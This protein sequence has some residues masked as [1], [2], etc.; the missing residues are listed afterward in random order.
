MCGSSRKRLRLAAGPPS[1]APPPAL[2]RASSRRAAT[3]RASDPRP[4]PPSQALPHGRLATPHAPRPCPRRLQLYAASSLAFNAAPLAG[5]ASPRASVAMA[6]VD[7]M[8][9]KY[10]V[11]GTVYDP[12][13]LST[14]FDLNWMREAELKHGRLCMLAVSGWLAVDYGIRFPGA[15][16]EGGSALTAHDRMCE[17]GHMWALLAIVGACELNHAAKIVPRLDADWSGHDLGNYGVDP[18]GMD[19]PDRRMAE[20]KNGRLAM[21]GFSGL[22]TQ[23]ALGAEAPYFHF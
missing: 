11:K 7:D 14:K 15:A 9:G 12:L 3:M 22:V 1:D 6:A 20:L 19:T 5:V 21:L 23:A 16:F 2:P 13:N 8:V 10:S 18:L 4:S 17:S